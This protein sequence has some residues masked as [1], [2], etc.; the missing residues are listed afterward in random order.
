MKRRKKWRNTYRGFS[1][2][3]NMESLK[4]YIVFGVILLAGVYIGKSSLGFFEG[5]KLTL[6]HNLMSPLKEISQGPQELHYLSLFF[7]QFA[8]LLVLFVCGFCAIAQ[9]VVLFVI[10]YQGLGYG[11]MA[12]YLYAN[13]EEAVWLY[14]MMILA[15]KIFM[16]AV[17]LILAG[18]DSIMYSLNYINMLR[19]NFDKRS[20]TVSTSSYCANFLGYGIL[21]LA[22]TGILALLGWLYNFII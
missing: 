14:V 6:L 11:F 5:E 16:S 21:T 10:F 8:L 9:P 3:G 20:V 2:K 4:F 19:T 15:P 7:T 18:K 17:L 1:I 13:S 22:Y 12:G